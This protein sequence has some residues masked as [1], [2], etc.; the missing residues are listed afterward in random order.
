MRIGIAAMGSV[1]GNGGG[2]DI[3][4]RY[5]VEALADNDSD[6]SYVI[7][8]SQGSQKTWSYRSWPSNVRFVP[9]YDIEPRRSALVR[10][11]QR[12]LWRTLALLVPAHHGDPYLARQ[13]DSLG[14]DLIHYPHTVVHPLSIRTPCVL[15][16]W[17]M[18]QEY[19]PQF[20]TDAEL[21]ARANTYMPS[22]EK[23]WHVIAPSAYTQ[24]TLIERYGTPAS[25]ITVIPH[26]IPKTLQ[27]TGA[28][29]MSRVRT[30]Y[31]LPD[32]YVYY[33][34]NPWPHKNHARL[35]AALRVY[36]D[37]YG[38]PPKLILSGRLR[39]ERWDAKILAVAAGMEDH[40]IDLG[41]VPLE[42]LPALYSA[43]TLMVFPSLF[44]G[45]G[46]PLVEAMACGCPI[47]AADA[48]T[49]PEITNGAA[50]LFDP[51]SPEN[52]AEAIRLVLHDQ[53]LRNTLIERGYQQLKRFDW[54]AIIPQLV[55][56]YERVVNRALKHPVRN[57]AMRCPTLPELPPPPPGETGLSATNFTNDT[58]SK[59]TRAIRAIR[60]KRVPIRCPT[61]PELPPPPPGKF[62]WPFDT[63]R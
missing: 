9:L 15:S 6:S 53:E 49:I 8:V 27:R 19:Y 63:V 16:F 59:T 52:I 35:M 42:D 41:F 51:F 28:D 7:L 50:F 32:E 61:L 17:D 3:Y 29:E 55:G 20:F 14:L 21:A 43:A 10:A 57:L 62:G 37:R 4:T 40:V 11:A 46:I 1:L 26:G 23:A 2:L 48:T 13:I 18:Q 44:E 60:G 12:L 38:P 24:H 5:L 47:A 30:K 31:N 45:F 54:E 33:P 34:A 22:V 36:Q 56:I 58:N 39:H 25:K